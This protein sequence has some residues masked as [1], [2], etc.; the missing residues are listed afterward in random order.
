[1][2]LLQLLSVRVTLYGE[3][4]CII[5]NFF[6]L[7][8][9]DIKIAFS[10]PANS[11]LKTVMLTMGEFDFDTLF[12]NTE[13]HY[14][15]DNGTD[16]NTLPTEVLYPVTTYLLWIVF[17]IIMPIVLTNLLVCAV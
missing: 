1:M 3:K 13:K 11:I 10:S 4:S 6:N 12:F 14:A 2:I 8:P 9:Q 7:S 16:P 5:Y 15:K 17:V